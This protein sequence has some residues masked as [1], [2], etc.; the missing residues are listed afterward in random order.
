MSIVSR[1]ALKPLE[2]G[3]DKVMA[4]GYGNVKLSKKLEVAMLEA[5]RVEKRLQQKVC[6]GWREGHGEV[7]GGVGAGGRG[8][9]MH[10]EVWGLEGGAWRG[11]GA[12]GRGIEMHGEVWRWG[13]WRRGRVR[14]GWRLGKRA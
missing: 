14:L 11:V 1:S 10:G 5:Q 7:W 4:E 8:I 2:A 12:G 9:E 3:V 13:R 6:G